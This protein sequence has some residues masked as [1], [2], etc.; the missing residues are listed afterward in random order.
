MLV[1]PQATSRPVRAL[2]SSE[3]FQQTAQ[4]PGINLSQRVMLR[5]GPWTA[6]RH[7]RPRAMKG[8]AP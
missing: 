6:A 5:Y 3:L 8:H 4:R 1:L 2:Y 7:E